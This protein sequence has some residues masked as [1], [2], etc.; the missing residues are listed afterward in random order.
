M[1]GR[2]DVIVLVELVSYVSHVASEGFGLSTYSTIAHFSAAMGGSISTC[3]NRRVAATQVGRAD[4]GFAAAFASRPDL[5]GFPPEVALAM[6]SLEAELSDSDSLADEQ[7]AAPVAVTPAPARQPPQMD[8]PCTP[9]PPK[10]NWRLRI[11][12]SQSPLT[13]PADVA[14]TDALFA[15]PA[16]NAVGAPLALPPAFSDAQ[17][18]PAQRVAGRLKVQ[19]PICKCGVRMNC[20]CMQLELDHF[21]QEFMAAHADSGVVSPPCAKRQRGGRPRGYGYGLVVPPNEFLED[22][23]DEMHSATFHMRMNLYNGQY[24]IANFRIGESSEDR[25]QL[26]LRAIQERMVSQAATPGRDSTQ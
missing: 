12:C 13:P 1:S 5:D 23:S 22:I 7:S 26:R 10:R 14:P 20:P 18:P 24:S 2:A 3:C 16:D 9:T 25:E 19:F 6:F 21:Q 17:Q 4:R 8:L 11:E 15:P